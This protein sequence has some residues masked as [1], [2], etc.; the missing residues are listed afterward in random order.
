MRSKIDEKSPQKMEGKREIESGSRR[1][2]E[3]KKKKV[4]RKIR[5]R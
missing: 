2:S 3:K 5:D 1:I 4:K